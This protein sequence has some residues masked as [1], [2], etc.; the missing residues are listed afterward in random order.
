MSTGT[1]RTMEVFAGTIKSAMEAY[2]GEGV[3]V[4]VQKVTKNNGLI[5]TGLTIMDKTSNLAPTIYLD[6]YFNDYNCSEPMSDI[7]RR[8]LKV[9][10]YLDKAYSI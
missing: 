2:F 7:C 8:I 3:R 9:Y 1:I 10:E 4:S 6:G 5:L